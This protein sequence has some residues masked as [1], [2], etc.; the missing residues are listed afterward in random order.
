M[1]LAEILNND[2]GVDY[3]TDEGNGS[4]EISLGD[5]PNSKVDDYFK[6]IE[7][8]LNAHAPSGNA[9]IIFTQGAKETIIT[10]LFMPLGFD[11]KDGSRILNINYK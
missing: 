4:V 2:L 1:D 5:I 10:V 3:L 6:V 8:A 11:A 9:T 7:Q